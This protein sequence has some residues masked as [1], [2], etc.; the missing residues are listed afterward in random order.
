MRK[1]AMQRYANDS[2]AIQNIPH[3][4]SGATMRMIL[5]W[6]VVLLSVPILLATIAGSQVVKHLH[7]KDT[8][9]NPV[10]LPYRFSLDTPSRREAADPTMLLYAGE[11][12]MF[13]SKS[14]GYWYSHDL[15]DWKFVKASGY[16]VE[17]YAPTVVAIGG[18]VYLMAGWTKK[19]F[20][21]QDLL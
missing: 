19:I 4:L 18:K 21:A 9:C 6:G 5:K 12:W 10:D 15:L 2:V 20:V 16:P 1:A 17:D 11:Y 3:G 13:P 7:G 8:Y 14:G